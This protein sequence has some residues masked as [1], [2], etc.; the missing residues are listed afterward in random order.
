[1]RQAFQPP[2]V[3]NGHHRRACD[4]GAARSLSR[5]RSGGVSGGKLSTGRPMAS[6][7]QASARTAL[8]RRVVKVSANRFSPIS[9]S[10]TDPTCLFAAPRVSSPPKNGTLPVRNSLPALCVARTTRSS[11]ELVQCA[12]PIREHRR[13]PPLYPCRVTQMRSSI[14]RRI[15]R[16]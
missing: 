8:V 12:H 5:R 16:R 2:A 10:P 11:V 6:A 13:A 7:T 1:M 9:Q 3:K 15:E 14:F 4:A